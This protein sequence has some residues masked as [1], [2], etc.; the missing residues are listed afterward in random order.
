MPLPKGTKYRYKKGTKV[1]L[2]ILKGKVIETKN[3]KSGKTHTFG[4]K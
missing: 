1:R 2:A 3:M 4:F